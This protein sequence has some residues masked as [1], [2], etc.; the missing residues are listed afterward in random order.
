MKKM[1]M[2]KTARGLLLG[3][4]LGLAL[5]LPAAAEVTEA[6]RER[7]EALALEYRWN[8]D[9]TPADDA[10]ARE[11]FYLRLIDECPETEAAER[12]HWALSNLYLD[13]F[14]EPRENDARQ[15]LERFVER[16]P[17]SRWVLHVTDR[18]AWFWGEKRP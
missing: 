1:W 9:R 13:D 14:D 10:A 6:E 15:I 7:Q 12:A 18:L 4:A 17:S 2:G 16:Y 5:N 3:V 8:I 11:G